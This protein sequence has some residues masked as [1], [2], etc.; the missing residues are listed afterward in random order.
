MS[1]AIK[2]MWEFKEAWWNTNGFCGRLHCD[3]ALQQLWDGTRGTQPVLTAYICGDR[4]LEWTKLGDPVKAGV[5]ELTQYFPEAQ[6]LFVQ[7]KLIDWI[8]DPYSLGAFS[9]Y[10]P[11]YTL[12]HAENMVEQCGRIHFAGEHTA[13]WVGFIEG[14]LE[15]AHRVVREVLQ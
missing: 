4:A 11:G 2:I 14:A 3:G 10:A 1:R 7:G 6:D 8:N 15:S 13:T 12:D 9:H 5:Y